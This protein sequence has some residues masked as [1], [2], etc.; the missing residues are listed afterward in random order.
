MKGPRRQVL[1][2]PQCPIAPVAASSRFR[3]PPVF[4]SGS[5]TFLRRGRGCG[6]A[7]RR[8]RVG[9]RACQPRRGEPVAPRRQV[10]EGALQLLISDLV[11]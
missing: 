7:L 5:A 9:R 6:P 3:G 8:G 1:R 2:A 4:P 10:E 11:S